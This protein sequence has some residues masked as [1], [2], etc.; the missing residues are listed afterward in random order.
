MKKILFTAFCIGLFSLSASAKPFGFDAGTNAGTSEFAPL[1]Q[2]EFEKKETLDFKNNPENYKQR[3]AKK[4]K[5]LDYKQGKMDIPQDVK[6]Q[7]N[8]QDTR[9]G[10]NNLQFIKDENGNIKIQGF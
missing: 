2:Y 5:Y 4:D 1:M 7:F 10:S 8:M 3:R 6:T 9:P